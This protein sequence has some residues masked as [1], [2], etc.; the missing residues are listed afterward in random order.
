MM[1]LDALL[2]AMPPC[3]QLM[4]SLISSL[5][6]RF[7]DATLYVD[8]DA[9]TLRHFDAAAACFM[10]MPPAAL[11]IRHADTFSFRLRDE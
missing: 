10:M 5:R 2:I 6:R 11:M 1:L 9:A 7:A 8:A 4:M 3:L